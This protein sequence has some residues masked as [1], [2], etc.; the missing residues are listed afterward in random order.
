MPPERVISPDG[1][2]LWLVTSEPEVRA[3][4]ADPRLTS[5]RQL[6]RN[7]QVPPILHVNQ[8]GR[9]GEDHARLRKLVASAF[10]T[11]KVA[12][13]RER[14]VGY[15][16]ELTD[17]MTG[18][19]DLVAEFAAPLPTA[20][21]CELLGVP[22]DHRSD[23]ADWTST[24]IGSTDPARVRDAV[25]SLHRFVVNLIEVRRAEPGDDVLSAWIAARSPDG[26]GLTDN[27][28]LSM[29]V[30]TMAAGIE[31]VTHVLS[32]GILLMIRDPQLR[33]GSDLVEQLIRF[34][35]PTVVSIRRF[36]TADVEIGGVTVPEGDTVLLVL[37][38]VDRDPAAL[39]EPPSPHLGFGHGPH[40]CLGI[41]L[42]K[43]ELEVAFETLRGRFPRLELA[44]PEAELVWRR[45]FRCHALRALPVRVD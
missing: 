21:I 3:G 32:H 41:H 22:D 11:G 31:N 6:V 8:R 39:A 9:D 40:H 38:S 44:V 17:G 16:E 29:A 18:T 36:A 12:A 27:E 42:A 20:V 7:G 34:T 25:A 23:F 14:V 2:S 5:N 28:L 33:V 37:T 4:L 45:S 15:A 1:Q 43:T 30:L 10:G 24:M 13:L 35:A 19:V 26:A